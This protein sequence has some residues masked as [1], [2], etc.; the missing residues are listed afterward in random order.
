MDVT[1]LIGESGSGKSYKAMIVARD[2]GI[3]YI[4]DDGLLIKGASVIAGKSAKSEKT[5]VGAVKRA[6]FMDNVHRNEVKNAIEIEKPNKLLIIGTS[7]RM[8]EKIVNALELPKVVKPIYIRDISNEEEIKVAKFHRKKQGK[9]VIPV[10]TVEIR[11]DFSGY[12]LDTLKIFKKKGNE[13][14]QTFEKSVVRPTFSY[15]GTYKITKNALAQIINH[16]ADK[17]EGIYKI[18]RIKIN[19]SEIGVNMKLEVIFEYGFH[20]NISAQKLQN[21]IKE[22]I[23]HMTG[24]HIIKIDIVAKSLHIKK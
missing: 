23:E 15:Y 14:T 12:F 3:N 13:P 8:I 9:H 20:L 24:K 1:A 6:I 4:I 5:T 2:N 21:K 18:Y 10:P 17:T 16:I 22:D 19:D 7:D 11:K